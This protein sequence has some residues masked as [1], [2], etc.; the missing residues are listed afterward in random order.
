MGLAAWF[1]WVLPPRWTGREARKRGGDGAVR[2]EST[3]D[4]WTPREFPAVSRPDA[5][6]A[7]RAGGAAAAGDTFV[8]LCH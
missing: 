5:V 1:E 7:M 2:D 6:A 3:S 4:R 8:G